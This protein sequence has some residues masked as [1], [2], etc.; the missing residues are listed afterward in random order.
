MV[1]QNI[2]GH[3]VLFGIVGEKNSGKTTLMEALIR[4]LTGRGFKVASI[5]HDGH[6]FEADRE[7]SDSWKISAC[8]KS[9][10][11]EAGRTDS[12]F[13]GGGCDSD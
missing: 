12:L 8:Q 4:I 9:K 6:D 5:K 10:E 1:Y 11:Y 3:P 7:G 13:S 2:A